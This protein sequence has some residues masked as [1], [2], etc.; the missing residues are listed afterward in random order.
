MRGRVILWTAFFAAGLL[1][2][3]CRMEISRFVFDAVALLAA[4]SIL[5]AVAGVGI[6]V[7]MYRRG[8][9]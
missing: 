2:I 7:E 5:A 3:L 6:L 9:N 8:R 4:G 1:M